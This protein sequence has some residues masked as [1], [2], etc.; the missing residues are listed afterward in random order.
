MHRAH[1]DLFTEVWFHKDTYFFIEGFIKNWVSFNS[2]LT[3]V[4]TKIKLESSVVQ[5]L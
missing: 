3:Q 4:I 1:N 2:F 5:L